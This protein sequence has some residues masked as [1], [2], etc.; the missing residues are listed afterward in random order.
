[1]A[2]FSTTFLIALAL[3]ANLMVVVDASE[4]L[5]AP[6]ELS[7]R[8]SEEEI[9]ISLLDEVEGSLGK[10]AASHR[11]SQIEATLRP[12]FAALP[13][14]THGNLEHSA[15]SYALQ[16]LFVARHGWVIKGLGTEAFKN[17][18]AAGILKDQVPAYIAGLFE[19][20][21]A[22]KGFALREIAILA[23]TVEHLIHNEAVSRLGAVFNVLK[24]SVTSPISEEEATEALD[25]YMMVYILGEN[26]NTM[27]SATARKL[28]QAM[29][30]VFLAWK[31]TQKFVDDIRKKIMKD[32]VVENFASL[33]KVVETAGEEYGTFQDFECRDMKEKLVKME[34]RGTGRVRLSDF[35]R[36]ALDGAWTFQESSGYLRSLGA[37]DESDPANPSVMMVNYIN[38]PSNCIASSGFYSVCCKNECEGLLGH[39][40]QNIGAPDAKPA[41]I[42][43]LVT[44]LPSQ[45]VTAPQ[46]ISAN[47]LQRLDDIAATHMGTVPLQSRL[48]AQWMHHVYPRECPYPHVSGTTDAKL[49][50]EWKEATGEDGTAT[51]EEIDAHVS[52]TVST[53]DASAQGDLPVEDLMPWSHEEELI[54]VRPVLT[55]Q[56]ASSLS[57][58]LRSIAFLGASGSFAFAVIQTAQKTFNSGSAALGNE[59]YLV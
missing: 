2:Q 32:G 15:V 5:K 12:I 21:L 40:E 16:R 53:I 42:A 58:A 8:V 39:L 59:K 19:E 9:R 57:S 4:F 50:E 17:S 20:R 13:K 51:K 52:R 56:P 14:N 54:V 43:G 38:S 22:G 33:S 7:E 47:L 31:D 26:P 30:E 18:S 23:S 36:P 35:Y 55:Q 1:M 49:P 24:L 28:N 11:L 10:G 46:K 34:Y 45:S 37:L 48:F 6:K 25:T 3:S 27:T 44:N 29:P 41:T